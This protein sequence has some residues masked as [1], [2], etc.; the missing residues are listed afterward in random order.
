MNVGRGAIGIETLT[1]ITDKQ[2]GQVPEEART[3]QQRSSNH[4]QKQRSDPRR[5]VVGADGEVGI[6]LV[7]ANSFHAQQQ[8]HPHAGSHD[9][10]V[11]VKDEPFDED[12]DEAWYRCEC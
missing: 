2:T 10:R 5:N 3:R 6:G 4:H 11:G 12:V 1:P 9:W 8:E 7:G